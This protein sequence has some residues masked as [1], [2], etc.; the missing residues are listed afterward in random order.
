[1]W[2]TVQSTITLG[3]F[4]FIIYGCMCG[5]LCCVVC[6]MSNPRQNADAVSRLPY[7]GAILQVHKFNQVE[8]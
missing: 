5:V 2:S 6:M 4:Y 3:Y 8:E 7:G 1:M